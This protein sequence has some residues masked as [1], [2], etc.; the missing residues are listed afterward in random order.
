MILGYNGD[1]GGDLVT[2]INLKDDYEK[3]LEGL[4]RYSENTIEQYVYQLGR[5]NYLFKDVDFKYDNFYH[6]STIDP[7]L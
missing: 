7:H 4:G 3:Y 1:I 6:I 5:I 2:N